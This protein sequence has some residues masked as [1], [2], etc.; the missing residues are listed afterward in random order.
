M[1]RPHSKPFLME[2]PLETRYGWIIKER[3]TMTDMQAFRQSRFKLPMGT[4]LAEEF[5][6][7]NWL[8][9]INLN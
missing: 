2:Q 8:L 3:I 7:G 5:V 4:T 6:H 9:E 1:Q